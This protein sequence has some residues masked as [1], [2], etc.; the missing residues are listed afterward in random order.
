[1]SFI[2][3][4]YT[5]I[6]IPPDVTL[7]KLLNSQGLTT[8]FI[9][10]VTIVL[11]RYEQRS[12]TAVDRADAL[13]DVIQYTATAR[14]REET[15]EAELPDETEVDA[16]EADCR[17]QASQ[18]IE[19]A[20]AF[21]EELVARSDG[22]HR[23]TYQKIPRYDRSVLAVALHAR[24]QLTDTQLGAAVT[25]YSEWK[26]YAKGRAALKIVPRE[27]LQLLEQRFQALT[28]GEA[29]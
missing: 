1:M 21:L 2:D 20:N 10:V 3:S 9:I 18:I 11:W 16:G 26:R 4:I 12:K 14:D 24:G 27:V 29:T 28:S 25:I 23:R 22:R 19:R 13:E 6:E 17:Q 8:L 5:F 15:V 7:W